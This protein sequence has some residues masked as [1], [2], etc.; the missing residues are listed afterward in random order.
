[1]AVAISHADGARAL[2]ASGASAAGPATRIDP[3]PTEFKRG[4]LEAHFGKHRGEWP[5]GMTREQY[6]RGAKDLLSRSPGGSVLGHTRG[7]GHI[8]R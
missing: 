4:Q 2:M 5:D 8:L 7:D 1:M 6:D 3:K